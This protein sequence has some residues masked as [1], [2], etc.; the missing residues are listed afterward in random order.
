MTSKV[1]S[2]VRSLTTTIMKFYYRSFAKFASHWG[3]HLACL[4]RD[5]VVSS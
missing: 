3:G 1:V 2:L 5:E 4:E